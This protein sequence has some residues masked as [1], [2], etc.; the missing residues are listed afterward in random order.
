M[1]NNQNTFVCRGKVVCDP[2]IDREAMSGDEYVYLKIR[3]RRRYR[4][5]ES[6]VTKKY[7]CTV[8]VWFFGKKK[9]MVYDRVAKGDE[10][11]VTGFLASLKWMDDAGKDH[12]SLGII[13]HSATWYK[14]DVEET[15]EEES[16]F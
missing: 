4:T 14:Q 15:E 12:D 8:N 6:S 5:E 16:V 10:L 2:K 3:L 13:G 11:E 7:D 1:I 9:D